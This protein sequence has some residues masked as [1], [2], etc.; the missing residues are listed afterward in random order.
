MKNIINCH[1]FYKSTLKDIK[2]CNTI[3]ENT[4]FYNSSISLLSI[5]SQ[6]V[7]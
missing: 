7:K 5:K 6:D 4:L 2:Y 1:I 3:I